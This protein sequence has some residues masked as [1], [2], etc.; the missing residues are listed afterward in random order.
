[1]TNI[2]A[3]KKTSAR[4]PKKKPAHMT[5]K[6]TLTFGSPAQAEACEQMADVLTESL[7]IYMESHHKANVCEIKKFMHV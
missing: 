1:M 2:T 5:I 3:T 7:R 4:K 6:M